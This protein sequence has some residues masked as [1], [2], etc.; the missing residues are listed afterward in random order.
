MVGRMENMLELIF[1]SDGP[2]RMKMEIY[3]RKIPHKKMG[4]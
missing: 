4:R 3:R 2:R 1:K